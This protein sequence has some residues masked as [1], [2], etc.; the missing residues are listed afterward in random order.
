MPTFT[1]TLVAVGLGGGAMVAETG[2][3]DAE[4]VL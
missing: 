3:V 2:V 1:L 4:C